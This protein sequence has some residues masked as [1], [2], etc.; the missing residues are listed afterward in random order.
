MPPNKVKGLFLTSFGF[1]CRIAYPFWLSL[2]IYTSVV[3]ISLYVYQ[4]PDFPDI[5]TKWTGLDKKWNDDIGLINYSNAGKSGTLFVRLFTPISLFVVA[6]LQL[7]FFHE[8]WL[9]MVRRAPHDQQ[10]RP[11][12]SREL[13]LISTYIAGE[14]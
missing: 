7:K 14:G 2:I 1:F 10:P 4:F 3:I 9:A 13:V 6:M 5:W 12:S 11:E 8:P